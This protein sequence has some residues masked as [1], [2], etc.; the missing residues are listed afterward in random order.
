MFFIVKPTLTQDIYISDFAQLTQG[1]QKGFIK[2]FAHMPQYSSTPVDRLW[3]SWRRSI[4][5]ATHQQ[6]RRW[7]C[8]WSADTKRA[9]L[10]FCGAS[11]DEWFETDWWKCECKLR[12][13]YYLYGQ[14][15]WKCK[16]CSAPSIRFGWLGKG[17]PPHDAGVNKGEA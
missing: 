2:L 8:W 3:S 16:S 12:R 14:R 4:P 6:Q 7:E 10:H 17:Y 9:S 11:G 1:P 15:F 5:V 13:T